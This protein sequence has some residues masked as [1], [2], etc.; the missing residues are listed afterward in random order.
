[1]P[2]TARDSSRLLIAEEPLQVLP[3]LAV[4]I[5]LNEAIILQQMHYWLKRSEHVMEGETWIYNTYSQWQQQFPFWGLNTIKRAVQQLEEC[6]IVTSTTRF[7]R[8]PIDKTKWYTINYHRL[9]DFCRSSTTQDGLSTTH[10]GSMDD[11]SWVNDDPNCTHSQ[12]LHTEITP[13]ILNPKIPRACA[14]TSGARE[15][16]VTPLPR[17]AYPPGFL[18][19]WDCYPHERRASKPACLQVWQTQALE[20]R[21]T[22]ILEKVERLKVTS[23]VGK[24]ATFIPLTLT[25]LTQGRYEDD[26][27]E[28]PRAILRGLGAREQRNAE[29]S[30]RLI[31]EMKHGRL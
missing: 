16:H 28:M 29:A 19:F 27:M 10:L 25:W 9:N 11:P 5:G 6:G 2:R 17:P 7:N 22:E 20:T 31:E 30:L 26:L 4:A 3:S 15:T 23:W 18:L 24:E 14:K 8:N 1:M 21:T 12:R 13:E